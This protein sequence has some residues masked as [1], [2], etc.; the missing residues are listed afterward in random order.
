MALGTRGDVQPYVAL[1]AGLR[2]AGYTVTI[3]APENFA[4]LATAHRLDFYPLE[5]DSR[6]LMAGHYGQKYI[7]TGRNQLRYL[8]T[9]A[10]MAEERGDAHLK[11]ALDATHNADAIVYNTYAWSGYH[12]GEKRGIPTFAAW[13][14]PFTPSKSQPPFSF[15][16]WLRLGK[17]FNRAS[18]ELYDV[19]MQVMFGG[20]LKRWRRDLGLP[21]MGRGIFAHMLMRNLPILHAYSPLVSPAAADWPPRFP[22][23][24]YWFMEQAWEPPAELVAFLAAGEPPVYVGFGSLVGPHV[25]RANRAAIDALRTTGQRGIVATSQT[26]IEGDDQIFVV[27][28]A[29]H[30]WLFPRVAAVMHH[31]GAGTTS[32]GLRAGVPTITVPFMLDQFYWGQ[33]VRAI[34]A[35]TAPIYARRLTTRRLARRIQTAV[36]DTTM[37]QRAKAIGEQLR[38]EDGIRNAVAFMRPYLDG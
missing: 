1:G 14:F 13:I 36:A 5:G 28:Y 26:D 17:W 3:A 32:A 8:Y 34:G 19:A 27:R 7:N 25:E 15:P 22:V 23:T 21:P 10:Q 18:F 6:T 12:I 16:P 24:G 11:V 38:Q 31:G 35:G 9:F 37:R 30:A 33:R 29:D 4:A 2:Q 20:V